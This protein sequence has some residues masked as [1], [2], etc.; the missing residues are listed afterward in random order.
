ML[1]E[2]SRDLV[3]HCLWG[4]DVGSL[5]LEADRRLII[6]R[7]LEHGGDRHVAFVLDR[8]PKDEIMDVIMRSRYLGRKTVNFWCLFFG[9][10]REETNCFLK[11]SPTLWPYS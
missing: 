10:P 9:L 1:S 2:E 7:C 3:G 6:E 5:D 4:A 8:F 11:P